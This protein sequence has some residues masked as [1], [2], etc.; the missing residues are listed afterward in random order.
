MTGWGRLS[1][2]QKIEIW[3]YEQIVYAQ[4]KIFPREWDA[5]GS[6]GFGDTNRLS[7]FGQTI[8]PSNS[9]QKKDNLP[10]SRLHR[11]GRPQSKIK[12]KQKERYVPRPCKRTKKNYGTWK[13][14][15]YQL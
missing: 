12:R 6:L 14:Q 4:P 3:Q 7:N 11:S 15:W 8:K 5:Q 10:N 1:T 2:V 9:Q 13:W